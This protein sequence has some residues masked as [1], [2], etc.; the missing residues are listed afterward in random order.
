MRIA[1]VGVETLRI[2]FREPFASGE[3]TWQRLGVTILTIRTDTG[4]SGLGELTT[5]S[6]DAPGEAQAAQLPA[7]LVGIHVDDGVA[8]ED[9]LRR[10][11]W[12]GSSGP[13]RA[14]VESAILDLQAQEQGR[15][16]AAFLSPDATSSVAVNGLIG[17]A[18]PEASSARAR[19]LV[20]AGFGCLK[21]KATADRDVLVARL[22]AVRTVAGPDVRLRIDFNGTLDVRSA[23][24]VLAALDRFGVEYVEQ[25]LPPTA[26]PGTL[27]DLRGRSG[28]PIAADES[29]RDL[30][31]AR[32]LIEARGAAG[33][34]V[35]PTRVGGLRAARAIVELATAAGVA[36]T[37][38]TLFETGI[39][40]AGALHLAA[41]VPDGHAHGLTSAELLA[42]DLLAQPLAV[43]RGRMGV[44]V[45]PGLGI[46]L[47]PSAVARYR[48]A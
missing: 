20:S 38:S 17:V 7:R 28:I 43:E 22:D 16:V 3:T 18:S 5:G 21:L 12:W 23:D 2:P 36:V 48:V 15:P 31:S 26:D 42:S 44:P 40:I 13:V 1:H 14:A 35:K 6:P 47:D 41:T 46:S 33:P 34:A 37:I 11:G 39:G 24:G 29:V 25:P 32:A 27:A 30:R 8:Q 4:L 9:A 45:A 10:I 19:A